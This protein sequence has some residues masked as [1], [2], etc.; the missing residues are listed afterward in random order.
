MS[1]ILC[2]DRGVGRM[3]VLVGENIG[4]EEM[5]EWTAVNGEGDLNFGFVGGPV[6]QS[7]ARIRHF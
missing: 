1:G 2:W 7:S 4:L 5:I 3:E 6:D